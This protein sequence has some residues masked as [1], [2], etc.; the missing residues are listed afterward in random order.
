MF[1]PWDNYNGHNCPTCPNL[2]PTLLPLKS[3]YVA[4]LFI[5]FIFTAPPCKLVGW[6]PIWWQ[7]RVPQ[8][9]T[10][11]LG[12]GVRKYRLKS[13]QCGAPPTALLCSGL[14]I[15]NFGVKYCEGRTWDFVFIKKV[16][17]W[18]SKLREL[19]M[20]LSPNKS[21]NLT[22]WHFPPQSSSLLTSAWE[23]PASLYQLV[24]SL[25]L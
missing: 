11:E 7:R 8:G 6:F 1:S 4:S 19:L 5:S 25:L 20:T 21:W 13:K 3:H 2:Y 12:V 9:D 23:M 17:V 10:S 15:F 18:F 24:Q 14:R 16:R 22:P